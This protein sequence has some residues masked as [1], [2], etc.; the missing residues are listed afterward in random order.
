MTIFKILL[1]VLMCSCIFSCVTEIPYENQSEV[2][3]INISGQFNNVLEK[4]EVIIKTIPGLS[5]DEPVVGDPISDAVVTVISS[6]GEQ[7]AFPHNGNGSYS[8]IISGTAGKSYKLMISRPNGSKYETP[9][10]EMKGN[11]TIDSLRVVP[12]L[13][14]IINTNG[15]VTK[16]QQVQVILNTKLHNGTVPFN[17]LYRITGEYEFQEDDIRIAPPLRICYIKQEFDVGNVVALSG[18]LLP[19]SRVTEKNIFKVNHDYRFLYQFGFQIDQYAIDQ[20]AFE[21][22]NQ[23]QKLTNIKSSIF[24]PPPGVLKSNIESKTDVFEQ[25]FGYF[26]VGSKVTKR[27]FTSSVKLKLGGQ[28]FCN[29]TFGARRRPECI[30]CR[31]FQGSSTVRP[32]YWPF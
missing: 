10:I 19:D 23:V 14:N 32:S 13:E 18:A 2:K 6:D 28:F 12:F 1:S 29:I 16:N 26:T 7:I 21:Y 31:L 22:W 27:V 11:A 15:S 30:D 25:V 4:Q 5:S 20:N 3:R 9:F 17:A 8:K 24:D